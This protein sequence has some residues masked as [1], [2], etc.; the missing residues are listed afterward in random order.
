MYSKSLLKDYEE[1]LKSGQIFFD[2]AYITANVNQKYIVGKDFNK[3]LEYEQC[4]YLHEYIWDDPFNSFHLD[5]PIYTPYTD[6]GDVILGSA[7]PM[8]ILSIEQVTYD[9]IPSWKKINKI[10]ILREGRQAE[11]RFPTKEQ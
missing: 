5:N 8:K 3:L 9:Y 4:Y 2:P 7:V 10:T 6:T 11:V 1:L